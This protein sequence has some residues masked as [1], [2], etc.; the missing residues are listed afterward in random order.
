VHHAVAYG[1]DVAL[2]SD[3]ADFF[4]CQE[5]YDFFHAFH[6]GGEG[7]L[8]HNFFFIVAPRASLW[9]PVREY[10]L[11]LANALDQAVAEHRFRAHFQQLVFA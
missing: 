6:M 3:N 8:T 2:A 11:R 10:S 5:L 4:V 1:G 7:V 9:Q